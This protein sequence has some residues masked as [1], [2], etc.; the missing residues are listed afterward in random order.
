MKLWINHFWQQP[1]MQ[2]CLY[3]LK[4]MKAEWM[5]STDMD[6]FVHVTYKENA[7]MSSNANASITKNSSLS[8][9]EASYRLHEFLDKVKT[10]KK[11]GAIKMK[12]IP[13]G[14]HPSRERA[15]G[16]QPM[17]LDYTWR[18]AGGGEAHGWHRTK[19]FFRL[20]NA[21]QIGVHWIYH[22]GQ[23]RPADADTELYVHHYKNP[24]KGVSVR[25]DARTLSPRDLA[26]D[27][28]LWDQYRNAIA[29]KLGIATATG[30]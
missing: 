30:L 1:M 4:R 11:V 23:T 25:G 28:R 21:F 29:K 12:S 13:Y 18:K 27:T 7:T 6:E 8:N 17:L 5:L 14:K 15:K 24:T 10:E 2:T 20:K 16:P 22:S 19:L 26:Q 9:K 3:R